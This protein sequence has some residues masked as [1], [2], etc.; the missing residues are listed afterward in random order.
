MQYRRD[1]NHYYKKLYIDKLPLLEN[2]T[3]DPD[4]LFANE[5]GEGYIDLKNC[6]SEMDKGNISPSDDKDKI[7]L[8]LLP[9][10]SVNNTNDVKLDESKI[11]KDEKGT[12]VNVLGYGPFNF[13]GRKLILKKLLEIQKLINEEYEI[14]LIKQQEMK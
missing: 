8:D 11:Q 12:F 14:E 3:I 2:Y 9:L 6:Q 7:Y 4:Y 13:K 5:N 1:G 10:L